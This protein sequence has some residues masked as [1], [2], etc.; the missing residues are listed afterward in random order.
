MAG[1]SSVLTISPTV[2]T[3]YRA[4]TTCSGLSDTSDP[5]QVV[6][7]PT[8]SGPIS[9]GPGTP[10]ATHFNTFAQFV[11]ALPCGVSGAVT[12]TVAPGIYTEQLILGQ[13]T[14]A[15]ATN[16]ITI[17]G[18]GATLTFSPSITS[19]RGVIKMNGTD[20][21]TINDLNIVV[22]D[23]A[24]YGY[25]VHMWNNADNNTINNCTINAKQDAT[26]TTHGGII[27]SGSETSATTTTTALCDNNIFSNN[28]IMG[29]YYGIT[30]VSATTAG[31]IGLN[32]QAIN[33]TITDIYLYG[34]YSSGPDNS[35]ISGNN[36]SRPNRVV[37]STFYGVYFAGGKGALINANKIHNPAGGNPG[38]NVLTAGVYFTSADATVALPNVV[39]NNIIY[40][41]N[42]GG[43]QYGL[44][45]SGSNYVSY[46]HNTISLDDAAKGPFVETYGFYQT[47]S[48]TNI[49][50]KNNIFSITRGGTGS[51][52]GAFLNTPAST[53][54]LN[55][56]N[57]YVASLGGN[58]FIGSENGN[59]HATLAAWQAASLQDA[60]SKAIAPI[61]TNAAAGNLLPKI[62]G[63]TGATGTGVA[64]D[65]TNA[66]PRAAT[67]DMG[68]YEYTVP[69]CG[70]ITP[71]TT[72]T[73][74]T[75]LCSG[76]LL[77]LNLTNPS[78]GSG[79]TYVWQTS[80]TVGGTY[81]DIPGTTSASPSA[82]VTFTGPLYYRALITC[83]AATATSNPVLVDQRAVNTG[84]VPLTVN[85]ASPQSATNFH[86]LNDAYNAIKCGISGPVTINVSPGTYNEQL[87]IKPI[88]GASA[89]NT[90]TFNGLPGATIAYTS[91]T[92]YAPGTIQLDGADFV[93]I[94]GLTINANGATATEYGAGVM[95]INGADNNTISGCT[96][97]AGTVATA[98]AFAGISFS[99]L[100][101]SFT[102]ATGS[103]GSNNMISNN[104]VTGG[105]YG[106]SM[107]ADD[108]T[109]MNNNQVIGNTVTDYYGYGV[110]ANGVNN[111]LI[112]NNNVSRPNRT[113]S[114][115][116]YGIALVT[117]AL[118]TEVEA[119]QVHNLHDANLASISTTYAYYSSGDATVGNENMFA[120]NIAYNFNGDGPHYGLYNTGAPYNRYYNNT[121]NFD[122]TASVTDDNTYGIYQTTSAAGL[123][124]RNNNVYISRGG[125]GINYGVYFNTV[126]TTFTASNNNYWI[127]GA[128]TNN[129]A[130]RNPTTYPVSGGI[131]A[132]A[133][134]EDANSVSIDPAF[135]GPSSGLL[136]PT[137]NALNDKGFVNSL[138]TVDYYNLPRGGTPDIGA[139]E[140]TG[141]PLSAHLLELSAARRGDD[142]LVS[143]TTAT[144]K[145]MSRYVIERSADGR[146]FTDA[147][148]VS[149]AGTTELQQAYN[150][151]D[152][153]AAAN[154]TTGMLYYRLRMIEIDE[155]HAH[156]KTV[157][158]AIATNT[159]DIISVYPNPFTTQ[160]IVKTDLQQAG[161]ATI[162]LRDVTGKQLLL[163]RANMTVGANS[164][165]L[166][167]LDNL[168]AGV[169]ELSIQVNGNRYVQ[170]LVK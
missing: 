13:I 86:T 55:N 83:G 8:L 133:T 134:A 80:A 122:N 110:Y 138:V 101:T 94:N 139:V 20:F 109:P 143:W 84:S 158:V 21:V 128:G 41:F 147:G 70:P 141:F 120:N 31:N 123:D 166:Q 111:A 155:N 43:I 160:V 161:E 29:G 154:A 23:N 49:E 167:G 164:T 106:I 22:G 135:I 146:D 16:T 67:P 45:N 92:I 145:D 87:I 81:G 169:Y 117:N 91:S 74:A 51:K 131:A 6:A 105:Y 61:F 37:I 168:P 33:N 48:A 163:Q 107:A 39:S 4:V 115:T 56:N 66:A 27:M 36:I 35:I 102:S 18:G 17:N 142:V 126:A 113:A 93:T 165:Q 119:N 7:I 2:T 132:W 170:K 28:T 88:P 44:Y 95:F 159:G 148:S 32:N 152:L 99:G 121:I 150:F 157:T 153:R 85:T 125:T 69:A 52:Y 118:N 130:Y 151:T 96:V 77:K 127:I 57:Y 124:Y 3:Y 64:N 156:S 140:F 72:T 137:N 79:Q 9:I 108:L 47:T 53:V 116:T 112:K 78:F 98:T 60:N 14:G 54:T 114:T 25:G 1:P 46:Y 65:I 59:P 30:M 100:T 136:Q 90:V 34:I 73:S 71:G 15:S 76:D 19:E 50:V 162:I 149:A 68:A 26:G 129:Y 5:I 103:A 38:D 144:E 89:T 104:T 62:D 82:L 42:S 58:N 75:A 40:N 10:S 63:F 11:S 97:N 24:D 12:V